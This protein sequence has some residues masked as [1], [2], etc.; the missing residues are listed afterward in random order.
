VDSN[1]I[2]HA[3]QLIARI[4]DLQILW[5]KSIGFGHSMK[6]N[7]CTDE[8]I[9]TILYFCTYLFY[10]LLYEANVLFSYHFSVYCC[11]DSTNN[12]PKQVKKMF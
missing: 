8:C 7:A 10:S 11:V 12:V 5:D 6:A 4:F 3:W 1:R 2:K 9:R